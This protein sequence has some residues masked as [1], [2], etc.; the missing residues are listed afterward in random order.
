MINTD[1]NDS[2]KRS[3]DD[4]QWD[5]ENVFPAFYGNLAHVL[6][7]N[8]KETLIKSFN[9]LYERYGIRPNA[10]IVSDDLIDPLHKAGYI[11]QDF[12]TGK[13]IFYGIPVYTTREKDVMVAVIREEGK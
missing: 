8:V 9:S 1:Y 6:S 11:D 7:T 5:R 3:A 13:I 4:M 12:R 2:I 10:F